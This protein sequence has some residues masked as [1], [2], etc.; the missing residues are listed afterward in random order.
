[1]NLPVH[2]IAI[3]GLTAL[4]VV[5]IVLRARPKSYPAKPAA[6]IGKCMTIGHRE[7]QEDNCA[8]EVTDA[9]ILAVLADGMGKR[10]GGRVA[11]RIAVQIFSDLFLDYN[12]FDNPQYYFRKAFHAAN[13][14]ILETVD[15]QR[16][17]ASVAAAMIRSGKLY[18]ALAGDVRIAVF[19]RGDLVPVSEGHTVDVLAQREF[20]RGRLTRQDAVA[21]LERHRLYNYVG[22]DGF[23]DIEFFDTPLTL[24]AQDTVV[25]M[26]DGVYD[27]LAW[28]EIEEVLEGK[29]SCQDKALEIIQRIN[30]CPVE[31][32]DN[33]SILLV[34]P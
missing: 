31:D 23:R 14:Q 25:L 26:S 29:G 4:L 5:L 22:Q 1:M 32:K 9:G 8:A 19:H 21:M 24:D 2:A 27:C 18:Y 7:V 3:L 17:S 6:D 13:R 20:R 28:R 15:E 30:R 16:G 12:A 10:Y 11:S 34:R 33:A